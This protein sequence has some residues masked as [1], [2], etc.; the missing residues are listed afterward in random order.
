MLYYKQKR[1]NRLYTF[2]ALMVLSVFE[3]LYFRLGFFSSCLFDDDNDDMDDIDDT[4]DTQT[5][6]PDLSYEKNYIWICHLFNFGN[7]NIAYYFTW[8]ELSSSFGVG[9]KLLNRE[10]KGDVSELSNFD[11]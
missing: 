11:S 10:D 8:F 1:K 3:R 9:L 4:D 7:C 5:D 6:V 2:V